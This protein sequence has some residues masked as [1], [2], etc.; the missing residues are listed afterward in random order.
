[1]VAFGGGARRPLGNIWRITAKRTDFYLDPVGT[2]GI[3]HLSVHGPNQKHPGEHRF[4]VKVDRDAALEAASNDYFVAHGLPR[5]GFGFMGQQLAP[6]VFHVARLRWS[7]VL[8]RSRYQQAA[9]NPWP[10]PELGR[11][12]SGRVMDWR[13]GHNE[14][15]DVDLIVS[16]NKPYWL[17]GEQSLKDNSRLG[18]VR[19]AAGLWLTATAFRRWQSQAPTPE[20]LVLP[21]PKPGE[22]PRPYLGGGPEQDNGPAMFWFLESITSRQFLQDSWTDGAH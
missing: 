8:T 5:K 6:G 13:L 14:A 7:W 20:N 1:M 2:A 19:N 11:D 17:G 18:P 21:L 16:Y 4:H 15:A 22:D 10:V 9:V 3:Y 12:T